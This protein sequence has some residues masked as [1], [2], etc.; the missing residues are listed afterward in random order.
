[1]KFPAGMMRH[2]LLRALFLPLLLSVLFGLTW[3]QPLS[4]QQIDID[5]PAGS[6]DFGGDVTTL[7]NGN[8]VVADP[9]YDEGGVDNIG[10]VYLY[11]GADLSLISVL[12]GSSADDRVGSSGVTVLSNGHY[13]VRS[14][15]WDNPSGPVTDVGAVT[16]CDG[17]S[18]CTGPV[19]TANSLVGGSAEDSVGSDGVTALSNGHYV[20]RSDDWD[21]PSGPVTDAGAVSYGDGATGTTGMVSSANSVLGTVTNGISD[22]DFDALRE[23]LIVG[24]GKSN[25]VTLFPAS[26]ALGIDKAV[27]DSTA[28]K[29]DTLTYTVVVSNSGSIDVSGGIISDT[30]PTGVNWVDGSTLLQPSSAGTPGSPPHL[31]SGLY[32]TAGTSV[33]LTYQVTVT[34]SQSVVT[35]KVSVT[36]TQ[37]ITPIAATAAFQLVQSLTVNKV[38]VGGPLGVDDFP[39]F[40]NDTPVTSGVAVELP[41]GPYVVS[42]TSSPDYS[43]AIG[44]DCDSGGNV[45]L[46]IGEQLTCTLTNTYEGAS[47]DEE[48][49]LPFVIR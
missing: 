30:L 38:V 34:G 36:T 9:E 10:A 5:G 46:G 26:I 32:I 7:P 28:K 39:L 13:V 4:A 3:A 19:T 41:A 6:G 47:N 16:W 25:I 35:N 21:N 17:A 31:A 11:R 15:L 23:R 44:G 20:V 1:M 33:T 8:F 40:I 18:G 42:E 48:I 45:T 43:V 27:S 24:R 14:A 12:K 37:V 2:S 22:V 29:G 49:F